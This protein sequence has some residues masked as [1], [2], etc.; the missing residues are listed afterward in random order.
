MDKPVLK[1][2]YLSLKQSHVT[3]IKIMATFEGIFETKKRFK[4]ITILVVACNKDH[5]LLGIDVLMKK[6]INSFKAVK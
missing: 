5:G 3:V 6:F 4:M 1:K 2:S